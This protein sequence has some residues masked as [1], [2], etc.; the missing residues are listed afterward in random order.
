MG[1][2]EIDI[3]FG[4]IHFCYFNF[5]LNYFDKNDSR[6]YYQMIYKLYI[7]EITY[8]LVRNIIYPFKPGCF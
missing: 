7:S 2:S 4:S 1:S 6:F 3:Y 8:K 5:K